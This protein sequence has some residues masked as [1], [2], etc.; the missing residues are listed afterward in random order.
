METKQ[1]TFSF[2]FATNKQNVNSPISLVKIHKGD[3][4]DEEGQD[5]VSKTQLPAIWTFEMWDRK[6]AAFPWIANQFLIMVQSEQ[7]N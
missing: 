5:K 4:S 7:T 2:S 3:E 6:K 1:K